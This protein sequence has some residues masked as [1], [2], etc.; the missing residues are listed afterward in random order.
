MNTTDSAS[1]DA[2][3]AKDLVFRA[4][5]MQTH[6]NTGPGAMTLA[7][8]LPFAWYSAAAACLT[9]MIIAFLS[10]GTYTKT[11]KA[12]AVIVT[13]G[14]LFPITADAEGTVEKVYVREGDTV[15]TGTPLMALRIEEDF[16]EDGDISDSRDGANEA[17]AIDTRIEVVESR[18]DGVVYQL[19]LRVGYRVTGN[20]NVAVIARSG[21][22]T[23]TVL[24]SAKAK[25]AV[26]V[27]D[28]VLLVLQGEDPGKATLSGRVQSVAL[29]PNEQYMRETRMTFRAYR[30]DIT[31]DADARSKRG[32][33][34]LGRTVEIRLPLQKR[35]IY[36]W[37]FDP[38][39]KLFG[40][41]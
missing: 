31:V 36:Q 23:V 7:V 37:L 40:T 15:R 25:S 38:L 22:P 28:K 32:E 30:V 35:R 6:S 18:A 41:D 10:F 27:N 34:L 12:E 9:C 16:A 8:P 20:T 4:E 14:G 24:V 21:K 19:P 29:S 3:G 11:E 33:I 17:P 39:R 1:R 5:A 13:A 2:V 26:K